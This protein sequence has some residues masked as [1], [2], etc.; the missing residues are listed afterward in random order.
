[1]KKFLV[2]SY[3]WMLCYLVERKK[4]EKLFAQIKFFEGLE[5]KEKAPVCAGAL[6]MNQI[7]LLDCFEYR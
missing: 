5:G 2:L 1:M 3:N 7:R 4:S 6:E